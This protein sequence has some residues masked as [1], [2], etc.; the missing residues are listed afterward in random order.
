MIPHK[1]TVRNKLDDPCKVSSGSVLAIINIIV[2]LTK[3]IVYV[4]AL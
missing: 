2:I 4:S 3:H 1:V